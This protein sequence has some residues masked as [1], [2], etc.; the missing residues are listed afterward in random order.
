MIRLFFLPFSVSYCSRRQTSVHV[1]HQMKIVEIILFEIL[2]SSLSYSQ[3][4]EGE[5][6]GWPAS[7]HYS[8]KKNKWVVFVRSSL[9]RQIFF[10]ECCLSMRVYVCFHSSLE[11][12]ETHSHS[13]HTERIKKKY[14]TRNKRTRWK[15]HTSSVDRW[16]WLMKR[17]TQPTYSRAQC[18]CHSVKARS[19]KYNKTNDDEIYRV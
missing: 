3:R 18:W 7:S 15:N 11:Y 13:M 16:I 8:Q 5:K 19:L 4:G 14:S 17:V 12:I 9:S 1:Q 2:F 6:K 10:F